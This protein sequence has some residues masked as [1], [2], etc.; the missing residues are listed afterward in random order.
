MNAN[1]I[2]RLPFYNSTTQWNHKNTWRNNKDNIQIKVKKMVYTTQKVENHF[3]CQL[4]CEKQG[5][6]DFLSQFLLSYFLK[7][8]YNITSTSS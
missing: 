1:N 6:Q 2:D 4:R 3:L 8:H 5:P 7:E